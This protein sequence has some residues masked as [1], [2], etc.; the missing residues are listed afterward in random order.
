RRAD[1]RFIPQSTR[2]ASFKHVLGCTWPACSSNRSRLFQQASGFCLAVFGTR[3]KNA[4][5]EIEPLL[6][7]I[8]LDV[9]PC[10]LLFIRLAV[11]KHRVH[12][13]ATLNTRGE[14]P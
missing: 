1:E 9:A 2:A 14:G 10:D 4:L 8:N 6:E 7:L 5:Q 11:R 12:D 3:S 13:G